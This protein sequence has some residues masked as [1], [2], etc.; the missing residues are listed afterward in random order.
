MTPENVLD[1]AISAER[2]GCT[3]ILFTLGERPEQRYPEAREWLQI[4]GYKTTL[5]YLH[6]VSAL[7]IEKTSILPHGKPGTMSRR[8]MESLK[9]VNVSMGIMLE[10]ISARLCEPGGPH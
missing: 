1:V 8:E 2:L 5:E 4:H 6:D 7:V 9:E 10:S 3:E